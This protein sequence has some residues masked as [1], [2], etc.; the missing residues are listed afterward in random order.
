MM[1]DKLVFRVVDWDQR[2]E[3]ARTLK[4]NGA[5]SEVPVSANLGRVA[6]QKLLK[7]PDSAEVLGVWYV[8]Q[9]LAA[10][11][12]RR[13]VLSDHGAALSSEDLARV[14]GWDVSVVERSLRVLCSEE[15]QLLEQVA[16]EVAL[17][18]PVIP[19]PPPRPPR[20][21][22]A[23]SA[24]RRPPRRGCHA[25]RSSRPRPR[26]TVCSPVR[27]CRRMALPQQFGVPAG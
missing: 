18:P 8:L 16:L 21:T 17:C 10:N 23:A 3:T 20:R 4:R 7:L 26:N 25:C 19:V 24:S 6:F 27:W 5:L 22:R 1:V 9:L 12:E 13:G 2:Y 11:C 15:I 14:C